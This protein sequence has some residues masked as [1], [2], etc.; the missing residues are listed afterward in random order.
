MD[1][2][3]SK[4]DLTTIVPISGTASKPGCYLPITP[5]YSDGTE[6]ALT[7]DGQDK[8][9]KNV[10]IDYSSDAGLF[11]KI[12]KDG[13]KLENLRL[14]DFDVRTSGGNAGTL[15]GTGIAE[16]DFEI[17]DV[18]AYNSS[19][20]RKVQNTGSGAAGGLIGSMS[21]G[22]VKDCG[23][24]VYVNSGG[25][26]G[27]LIGSTSGAEITQSYCGGYTR[28]IFEISTGITAVERDILITGSGAAGG[29]VGSMT[30]GSVNKCAAGV[31]VNGG[32]NAGGLI[33]ESSGGTVSASYSAGHTYSGKPSGN[34]EIKYNTHP[35][36]YP[37]RYYDADNNPMYNVKA[38][39]GN[40]G[41]LI[42]NAGSTA[43]SYS[44]STCSASGTTAG[45]FV[46]TGGGTIKNC[47]CT[48]LVSGTTV[49]AFT[50]DASASATG[51]QY[52]EIINERKDTDTGGYTYLGP[53]SGTGTSGI[54]ALDADVNAY[55]L[56]SGSGWSPA[57]PYDAM[58]R[59][60]YQSKYNLK[61][62]AQLGASVST[63]DFVATHYGDWPAPEEFVFN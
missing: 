31:L 24:A 6:L 32:T 29:L 25:A 43:V 42:G 47:Y 51:C 61:T 58:L 3:Q 23:A 21:T 27:G 18:I 19:A 55:N 56:F 62:V 38:S 11:G 59:T 33:G 60:Y 49:G 37:S 8:E 22:T 36:V 28:Q 34:P 41:G 14:I 2:N 16:T 35:S 4:T 46:G 7:Y 45:G 54:A 48:G 10:E 9:I 63:S 17:H 50:G 12:S 5:K 39:S 44:Y 40:A 53:T 1:W 13:T 20:A 57:E 30:G 26:A 15:L 52:F